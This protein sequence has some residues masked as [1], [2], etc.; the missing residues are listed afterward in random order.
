MESTGVYWESITFLNL[1]NWHKR[2]LYRFSITSY[3][4]TCTKF[5]ANPIYHPGFPG[6]STIKNLAVM[7]ETWV[8]S[9]VGKISWR[10]F[11][12]P[13]LVFLPGESHGQ[14]S[15]AGYSPWGHKELDTTEWLR[16][17]RIYHLISLRLFF[18]SSH[19]SAHLVVREWG[20]EEKNRNYSDDY[21][22]GSEGLKKLCDPASWSPE[23]L[24]IKNFPNFILT[25]KI[26]DLFEGNRV[27]QRWSMKER[28]LGIQCPHFT[29]HFFFSIPWT[30]RGKN[31]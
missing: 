21:R 12:Q 26:D 9:W 16:T 24:W 29:C 19:P 10:R 28:I 3:R 2:S 27:S 7:W 20:Q 17:Q 18:F 8:Q 22:Q 1:L 14:R 11:W 30:Q 6:G 25:Q 31:K 4:K 13:T 5:L 23:K 15:L